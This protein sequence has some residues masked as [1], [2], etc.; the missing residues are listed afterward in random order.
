MS[1]ARLF[2]DIFC[3]QDDEGVFVS[4][5]GARIESALSEGFWPEG[6]EAAVHATELETGAPRSE[7]GMAIKR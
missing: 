7:I 6:F 5:P 2:A 3:A 4:H 1:R